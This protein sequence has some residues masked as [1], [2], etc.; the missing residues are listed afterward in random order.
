MEIQQPLV[1]IVTPVFNSAIF[2]SSAIESV[3]NQTYKTWEHILVDDGSEDNSVA[4]I[5]KYAA[6]DKRIKLLR[7]TFNQGSGPARNL[8]IKAAKG[9]YIAFLDSDDI[10]VPERLEKHIEFMLDNSL[11]VS[12]ASYGYIKENGKVFRKPYLVS[13]MPVD[14]NYLLK[15]TD[16][17]C[18][19]AIFDQE[20]IG[21]FYMPDLRRKQDYAL[22][23]SILKNGNVSVPFNRYEILAY[24]RQRKGSATNNKWLLLIKHFLF[25]RRQEKLNIYKSIK[26]TIYWIIGGLA[27]HVF[28]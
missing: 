25:L 10:W 15:H 5:E 7:L 18:L 28:N 21:K 4:I 12:H 16:I 19:T 27:K 23:L 2:L 20:I 22:W 26:Y 6:N 3:Q 13:N 1:S 14:Y 9:K 17:S 8:A 11:A 24:Y